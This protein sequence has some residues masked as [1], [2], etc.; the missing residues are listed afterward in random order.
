ML[1]IAVCLMLIFL[2]FGF[3]AFLVNEERH[4]KDVRIYI[5]G[6]MTGYENFNFAEFNKMENDILINFDWVS[7]VNPV[8][9][10]KKVEEVKKNPTYEDYL[11]EDFRGLI[12]CDAV[13]LLDGWRNSGGCQKEVS[14]A[15]FL[16]IPCFESYAELEK[17]LK[18]KK[19]C[20]GSSEK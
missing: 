15:R 3:G 9:I 20:K 2:F 6:P 19:G 17:F 4:Y 1:S 18:D 10:S 5:S 8:A 16:S 13:I 11:R 12:D 14:I 7:V